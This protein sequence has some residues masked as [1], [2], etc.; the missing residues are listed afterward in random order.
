MI[1][2]GSKRRPYDQ[3]RSGLGTDLL[4][5]FILCNLANLCESF[6]CMGCKWDEY[7]KKERAIGSIL[8]GRLSSCLS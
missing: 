7:D 6:G 8:R 2:S 1:H 4:H 3:G 5:V